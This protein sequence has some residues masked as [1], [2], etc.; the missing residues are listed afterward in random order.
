M[1][2]RRRRNRLDNALFNASSLAII[3]FASLCMHSSRAQTSQG[4]AKPTM[5]AGAANAETVRYLEAF[6][7]SDKDGDGKLSREEAE[8]LPAIAQRFEQIDVDRD[9]SISKSEYLEAL[10]P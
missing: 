8:N 6:E 3:A 5:T 2:S 9:G 1:T 4:N 10:K 7:R